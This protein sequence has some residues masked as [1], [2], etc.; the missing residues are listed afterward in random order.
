MKDG[1]S[2]GDIPE[3]SKQRAKSVDISNNVITDGVQLA[4]DA[5]LILAYC[6][7]LLCNGC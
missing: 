2:R 1:E 7:L 4:L 3:S 5:V 6:Y